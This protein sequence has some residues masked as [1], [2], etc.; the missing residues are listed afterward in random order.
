MQVSRK[1]VGSSGFVLGIDLKP[2][3]AVEFSNVQLI[4]GD[5]ADPELTT[6]ILSLL[7]RPPDVVI[8]DV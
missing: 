1:I 7:P 2:L 4:C 8:S 5:V 6:I 3:D